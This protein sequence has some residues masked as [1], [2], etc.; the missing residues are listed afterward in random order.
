[1]R[2]MP[3]VRIRPEQPADA[4]AI[5]DL[6]RAAFAGAS[7]TCGYEWRIP[8]LLREAGALTVSLVADGEGTLIGHVALSP[9]QVD[10]R[11]VG[12][13]GLGPIAVQPA[14][15]RQGIGSRL[16]RAALDRLRERGATGCVLVGDPRFY[17][18]FGFVAD[19][20]LVLPGVPPEYLLSLRPAADRV[21]GVVRFHRAFDPDDPSPDATRS[22]DR[23]AAGA[24]PG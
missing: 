22:G 19:P 8:D 5:R 15:Q 2:R 9:V 6:T 21:A 4:G 13:V 17:G 20:A 3:A 7:H 10:G 23:P 14:W 16:V 24:M 11:E 1:M 18:R 12:L